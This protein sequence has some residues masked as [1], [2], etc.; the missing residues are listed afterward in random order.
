LNLQK[1]FGK[2]EKIASYVCLRS[3]EFNPKSSLFSKSIKLML[4]PQIHAKVFTEFRRNTTNLR[5]S[6]EFL[7]FSVPTEFHKHLHASP[8]LVLADD[9]SEGVELLVVIVRVAD[10]VEGVGGVDRLVRHW[11]SHLFVQRR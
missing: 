4:V 11:R 7:C 1:Q 9:I 10:V 3:L 6:A 5:N 8:Q 2:I